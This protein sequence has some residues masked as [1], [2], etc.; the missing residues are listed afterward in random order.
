MRFVFLILLAILAVAAFATAILL[1]N[2][3]LFATSISLA[4]AA[5]LADRRYRE[6]FELAE[7][8]KR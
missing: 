1:N 3:I 7:L 2:V 5:Y 4:L 6:Y 8:K